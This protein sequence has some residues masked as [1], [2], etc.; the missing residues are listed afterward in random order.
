MDEVGVRD[1]EGKGRG[2]SGK[3]PNQKWGAPATLPK[4]TRGSPRGEGG[5]NGN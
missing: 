5:G 1:S 3:E 2:L 4:I